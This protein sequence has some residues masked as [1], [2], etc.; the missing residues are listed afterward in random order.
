MLGGFFTSYLLLYVQLNIMEYMTVACLF[1]FMPFGIFLRAFEPTR[2]FGGTLLGL[3]LTF[4]LFYPIMIVLDDYVMFVP[5]NNELVELRKNAD[6]AEQHTS[7]EAQV[8]AGKRVLE[9]QEEILE[10]KGTGA[11]WISTSAANGMLAVMKPAML[12]VMAAVILPVINF[13]IL[14]EIARSLTSMLG[15]DLDVSNLT[16]MI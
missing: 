3:S 1:Y 15:E 7:K 6:V 14:V 16:R 10:G 2:K 5:I 8:E 4:V 11:A 13:A 12:Y 9:A